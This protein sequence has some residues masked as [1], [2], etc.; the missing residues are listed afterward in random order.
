MKIKTRSL[1]AVRVISK[2]RKMGPRDVVQLFEDYFEESAIVIAKSEEKE[3]F[4]FGIDSDITYEAMKSG[5]FREPHFE[6]LAIAILREEDNCLDLGANHGSHSLI[7]ANICSKGKIFAFEPQSLVSQIFSLNVYL[8]QNANI[9]IFNLAVGARTGN[10]VNI[11]QIK[12]NV[13]Q[14]NSGWSRLKSS[15]SL[16]KAIT[17]ARDDL[18]LPKIS[19]IKMDIQ[20]SE[21][22]ALK[23]MKRLLSN[24]RPY[25]FFEVEDVHLNFL[26]TTKGEL[27]REITNNSY[28]IYRIETESPSDHLAVPFERINQFQEMMKEKSFSYSINKLEFE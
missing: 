4:L 17:V 8:N 6:E 16:H 20:G 27:F 11:E 1:R 14:L 18:K 19:F 3:K 24:D 5:V 23:G 26:G 15:P 2:M 9:V 10:I 22:F 21:F 25:I 13:R 12:T 28:A 7:L